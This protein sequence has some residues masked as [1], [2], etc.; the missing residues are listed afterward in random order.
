MPTRTAVN[1]K[2]ANINKEVG[3]SSPEATIRWLL[4]RLTTFVDEPDDDSD[5]DS[6][7]SVNAYASEDTSLDSTA[8]SS[9]M[10]MGSQPVY[11]SLDEDSGPDMPI[12]VDPRF[13]SL[14]TQYTGLNGRANKIADTCY[15]FWVGGALDVGCTPAY[16]R[17]ARRNV[18][19][20]H[21]QIM[22]NLHQ[23]DFMPIRRYLLGKT[24]HRIGGFGKL[25]GDPPD[26]YHSYLGLAALALYGLDGTDTLS[27]ST[28]DV[29][30]KGARNADKYIINGLDPTLCFSVRAKLW[31]ENL[32][33]RKEILEPTKS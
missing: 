21:K 33:W 1:P 17:V 28:E 7:S 15:A 20:T 18:K 12:P 27:S 31:L 26:I 25:P 19:L 5:N 13:E 29:A 8:E 3:L 32:P 10:K 24:Q 30:S 4:S 14:S 2:F 16:L 6:V 11:S 23:F 9:F 22:D